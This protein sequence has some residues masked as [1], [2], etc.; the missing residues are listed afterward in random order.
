MLAL[1][2][3]Q[4]GSKGSVIFTLE[5]N[6]QGRRKNIKGANSLHYLFLFANV[7]FGRYVSKG[8]IK[9]IQRNES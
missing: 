2:V 6:F 1:F 7:G 9:I 5:F 8:M 3:Y 4:N